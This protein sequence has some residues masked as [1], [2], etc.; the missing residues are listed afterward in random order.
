MREPH[1]L[2]WTPFNL[3]SGRVVED[4]QSSVLTIT[5]NAREAPIL[6]P[7]TDV[8]QNLQLL[9]I[10]QLHSTQSD[11]TN[12]AKLQNSWSCNLNDRHPE[13]TFQNNNRVLGTVA[14]VCKPIRYVLEYLLLENN[15]V[16]CN[17]FI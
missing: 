15:F 9:E 11:N 12:S 5:A 3:I 6:L 2:I 13:R 10:D 14:E 1:H 8:K 7:T 16:Y 17:R 4:D